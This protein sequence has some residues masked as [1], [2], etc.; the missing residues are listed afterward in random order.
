MKKTIL[1]SLILFFLFSLSYLVQAYDFERVIGVSGGREIKYWCDRADDGTYTC[2]CQNYVSDCQVGRF[3]SDPICA[4]CGDCT[5]DNFLGLGINIANIIF[6]YLGIVALILFIIG[7]LRWIT[8]GGSS[9][10]IAQ[11]KRIIT[12]AVVG[13]VIVV[14][15][16][17]IVRIFGETIGVEMEEY[18]NVSDIEA[19]RRPELAIEDE[20]IE[21]L[22]DVC[23][24][25]EQRDPFT[26]WCFDCP[27]HGANQGCERGP[28]GDYIASLEG[29][30]YSDCWGISETKFDNLTQ[31]CTQDFQTDYNSGKWNNNTPPDKQIRDGSEDGVVDADTYL[32]VVTG[33]D[34]ALLGLRKEEEWPDCPLPP[35]VFATWQYDSGTGE[36]CVHSSVISYQNTLNDWGFICGYTSDVEE[37]IKFDA[38]A[39]QCTRDFQ[40]T[41]SDISDL[42]L[43]A[44]DATVIPL[45]TGEVDYETYKAYTNRFYNA[46]NYIG[47]YK[48]A[49]N[50][51]GC[52]CDLVDWWKTS[53]PAEIPVNLENCTKKFEAT[54]LSLSNNIE[55]FYPD[56]KISVSLTQSG[57]IDKNTITVFDSEAPD[58]INLVKNT[59]PWVY[60]DYRSGP[61]AWTENWCVFE[62]II[63]EWPQCAHNTEI[64]GLRVLDYFPWK[65]TFTLGRGCQG[66]GVDAYVNKL[67]NDYGCYCGDDGPGKYG[68]NIE[69][70]TKDFQKAFNNLKYN[71]T[72]ALEENGFVDSRTYDYVFN[73]VGGAVV[74]W[75]EPYCDQ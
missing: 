7:G 2:K 50:G 16:T 38:Q 70:C 29:L 61:Q 54:M 39:Q 45:I 62:G 17:L 1:I 36:G 31:A 58:L 10:K 67:E 4:C 49:L 64:N 35:T 23:V 40:T 65:Y 75:P 55:D 37:G 6:K 22:W 48:N 34:I 46:L 33:P 74:S 15:A 25:P 3:I 68:S 57:E 47:N 13:I 21:G 12:A 66:S 44:T 73:G 41:I 69:Q 60:E 53:V 28:V 32:A 27:V 11:G 8:S 19:P 18:L 59:F 72:P 51:W 14:F 5:L 24:Y 26:W 20:D 52:D 56:Y 30:G 42:Y 43:H 63:S 9:E 71:S